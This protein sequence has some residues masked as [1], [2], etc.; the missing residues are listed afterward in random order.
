MY[1]R[2]C[3]YV[4]RQY[5]SAHSRPSQST[6]SIHTEGLVMRRWL[7]CNFDNRCFSPP[8]NSL[9]SFPTLGQRVTNFRIQESL[10][11]SMQRFHACIRLFQINSLLRKPLTLIPIIIYSNYLLSYLGG[12]LETLGDERVYLFDDP[13]RKRVRLDR[14][15]LTG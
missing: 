12:P 2:R 13:L 4:S 7:T 3:T 6:P 1:E 14:L 15:N 11:D 5:V 8:W 9:S 10:R